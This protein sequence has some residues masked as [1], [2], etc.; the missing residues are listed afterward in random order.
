MAIDRLT[1]KKLE[2]LHGGVVKTFVLHELRYYGKS[3]NIKKNATKIAHEEI[4]IPA[5][6][7]I[8]QLL[9]N[10]H[11]ESFSL[12]EKAY[13]EKYGSDEWKRINLV[14]REFMREKLKKFTKKH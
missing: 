7:L 10:V 9:E 6:F 5:N 11:H 4:I 3:K 12:I 1:E 8:F 14:L 2:E 13:R